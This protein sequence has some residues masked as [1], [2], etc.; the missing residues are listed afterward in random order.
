MKI[1]GMMGTLAIVLAST[2]P[3]YATTQAA[4]AGHVWSG[5]GHWQEPDLCLSNPAWDLV[6][7]TCSGTRTLIIPMQ[8]APNSRQ[9]AYVRLIGNGT[10]ASTTFCQALSITANNALFD[11]SAKT[12]T[13]SPTQVTFDLGAFNVPWEAAVHFECK[14]GQGGGVFNV[15]LEQE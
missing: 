2:M 13:I 8:I 6:T 3:S 14:I 15:E 4:M 7:N 11:F 10:S 12:A 1:Q 5:G 9:H